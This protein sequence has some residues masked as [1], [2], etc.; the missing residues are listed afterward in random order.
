MTKVE[1]NVSTVARLCLLVLALA[2]VVVGLLEI[3]IE[4]VR[5]IV[6]GIGLGL[7]CVVWAAMHTLSGL[8][9]RQGF[10]HALGLVILW[11]GVTATVDFQTWVEA[12]MIL[13]ITWTTILVFVVASCAPFDIKVSL[14][15][16]QSAET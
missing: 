4:S 11:L 1:L 8:S 15:S 7:A 13:L 3:D 2:G 14:E 16:D 6:W 10:F 5:A 9:A 12:G